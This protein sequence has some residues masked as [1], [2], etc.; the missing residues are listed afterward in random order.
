MSDRAAHGALSAALQAG[1]VREL[2]AAWR[3]L[4]DAYFRSALTAPTLDL[5]ASRG[6]LGRWIPGTRTL[7]I[8][9]SLVQEHPWGA[10]IEVLKHEMAHQYVHEVL[11]ETLQT[12]HGPAFRDACARLGVDRDASGVPSV[13]SPGPTGAED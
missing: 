3:Q 6:T 5:V 12:P 8:S 4:N 11:G 13:P 1:L 10:V 7:E 9:R 2:R